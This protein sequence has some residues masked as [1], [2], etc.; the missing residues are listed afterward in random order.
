[1]RKMKFSDMGGFRIFGQWLPTHHAKISFSCCAAAA[2]QLQESVDFPKLGHTDVH[3]V[4][5]MD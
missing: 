5:G 4:V 3:V 1:M 2:E